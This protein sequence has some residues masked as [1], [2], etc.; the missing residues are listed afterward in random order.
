MDTTQ[1]LLQKDISDMLG[2]NGLSETEQAVFQEK[3]GDAVMESALLRLVADLN[4]DQEAALEQYLEEE[5]DPEE[6]MRHLVEHHADF[7]T[8]L[9]EEIAAFKE[10]V[11]A[12]LGEPTAT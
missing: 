11:L 12:V 6:L 1:T 7:E 4:A 8:I 10:E 3:I 2:M 5:P 9:T